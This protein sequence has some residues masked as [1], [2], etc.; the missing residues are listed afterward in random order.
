MKDVVSLQHLGVAQMTLLMHRDQV[1]K[2]SA[3]G[4]C[5]DNETVARGPNNAGCG[6]QY[7][8]YGCCPDTHTPAAGEDYSGCPCNTYTYGCCPDGVSVAQGPDT[9]GCGC[10][11]E[12]FGCCKDRRTPASGPEYEGCG[13]AESEFGCCPD[14]VTPATG[15]FFEGCQDEV[16]I[17]PGE[18][19]GYT[20]DRG[21][22]TNFTVK[23]FFDMDY[24][25]CTHF[26][27]GG[28]EGNLNKFNTQEEC[29]SA[30][31]EPEGM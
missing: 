1:F 27:Y 19:C 30:C 25:G 3:F 18:V 28:C 29:K 12:K 5:P 21:P 20:K 17:I 8:Q 11:Y 22:C 26:W 16:S 24:G 9:E 6:C 4:C 14:G 13:C 10:E 7:T 2:Y 15:K 31:V 23:W